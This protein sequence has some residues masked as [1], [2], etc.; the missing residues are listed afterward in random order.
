M[1][2]TDRWTAAEL[3]GIDGAQ[4]VVGSLVGPGSHAVTI[5]LVPKSDES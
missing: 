2:A 3:E 1:A 5:R 4:E